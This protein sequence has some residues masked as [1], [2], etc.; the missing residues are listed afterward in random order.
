MDIFS[1]TLLV[2][3]PAAQSGKGLLIAQRAHELLR[4]E[5]GPDANLE[6]FF[7]DHPGSAKDLLC[8]QAARYSCVIALGGDGVIHEVANGLMACEGGCRT[9]GVIPA[10]SGNDYARTLGMSQQVERAVEQLLQRRVRPVDLGRVNGEYFTQTLS[11]G[12]DAAIALGTMERRKKTGKHGTMLYLE[13]GLQQLR[14]MQMYPYSLELRGPQGGVTEALQGKG[15]LLAVQNGPTYGGG[16]RVTPDA[17]PSDGLLDICIANGPIS[18][19]H[20]TAVFL[21]AKNGRHVSSPIIEFHRAPALS[22]S[23]PEAAPPCQ[24]DG[25]PLTADRYEVSVAPGALNVLVGEE[26]PN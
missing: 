10:G 22:I 12:L 8:T 5:L 3:N 7:T 24:V 4:R 15:L 21:R 16:F 11:F 26:P 23:F 1:N 2:A 25:E 6:L 17:S 9:L 13:E 19:L 18:R 20:A 14:H